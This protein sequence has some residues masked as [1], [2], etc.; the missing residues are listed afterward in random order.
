M[1]LS[2]RCENPDC[3]KPLR[4]TDEL[5][6]KRVKCPACGQVMS[7]AAQAAASEPRA[8]EPESATISTSKTVAGPPGVAQG[9]WPRLPWFAG[10]AAGFLLVGV[11]FV[12]FYI[13]TGWHGTYPKASNTEPAVSTQPEP[14]RSQEPPMTSPALE[15][16]QQ[17]LPSRT[18]PTTTPQEA[19]QAKKSLFTFAPLAK[20]KDK[21]PGD[22]KVVLGTTK[23]GRLTAYATSFRLEVQSVNCP[24]SGWVSFELLGIADQT[25]VSVYINDQE[26]WKHHGSKEDA[27]VSPAI[28]LT[29]QERK[30]KAFPLVLRVGEGAFPAGGIQVFSVYEEQPPAVKN[31]AAGEAGKTAGLTSEQARV[32]PELLRAFPK[33][34][35]DRCYLQ[36]VMLNG[37]QRNKKD[38]LQLEPNSVRLVTDDPTKLNVLQGFPQLGEPTGTAEGSTYVQHVGITRVRWHSWGDGIELGQEEKHPEFGYMWVRTTAECY[39]QFFNWRSKCDGNAQ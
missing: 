1:S 2:I 8:F 5:A 6:G 18:A 37:M 21:C 3:R 20:D 13:M 23:D 9:R 31:T 36:F 16:E 33:D 35:W 32:W 11:G 12:V 34:F 19:K 10:V 24:A 29:D 22:M 28:Q 26:V 38:I 4:V 30:G 39:Q 7:V 25:I 27:R 14:N 15:S 17:R